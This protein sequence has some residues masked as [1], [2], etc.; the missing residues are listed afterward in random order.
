MLTFPQID[1]IA[2]DIGPI[3]I[4]W[5]GLAYLIG[6]AIV[7]LLG[8]QRAKAPYSVIKP[9]AI[10]DMVYYGALGVI[11]G[12]RLGYILFYDFSSV[13][14]DP[15]IIL[16]VW[17]GGMSFHGGMIGVFIAMWW[18]ARNQNCM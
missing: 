2:I 6:F 3:Q 14:E 8:K 10:D 18:F 13:I 16:K 4:H 5:Y 11:L 17:Q 7:W 1:P 15:L 9:E 12:G